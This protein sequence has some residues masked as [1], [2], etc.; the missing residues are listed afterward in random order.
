MILTVTLNAAIDKRYVIENLQPDS[1][2]R[3]KEVTC[4]AG[5]KGLNVSRIAVIAGEKVTATGFIGGHAG[6]YIAE[7]I[8]EMNIKNAFVK[9][10]GESRT[11][12]NI[13]DETKHTQTELLEPGVHVTDSDK[14]E[15]LK[16]YTRLV[17]NCSVVAIS[18]SVPK[19]VDSSLY[20]S[21][22]MIAKDIGKKVILDTSGTL[23]SDCIAAGPTMIKPNL[24]EIK[25]LTGEDML[26]MEDIVQAAVRIHKSGVEIVN[27]TLGGDGA[28][29]A[30]REG[31]YR[32]VVPKLDTV[33][34]VGCGDAA[35]AG[36]AIGLSRGLSM[37]DT[38]RL[39]SAISAA[40]AMRIETGFYLPK[41]MED[42][43]PRITVEKIREI[44]KEN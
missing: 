5:G 30:C 36:F 23:L 15:F 17:K 27:V 1:V 4:S 11:C 43:L 37:E 7:S 31:I 24:D 35:T 32:A 22:I 6:N 38:I 14:E 42:L 19:G 2:M 20:K 40:S 39:A 9:I 16:N 29:V 3:V 10:Q 13:Y 28:I 44:E 34:T 18:G 26:G 12:I 25:L 8:E 21:L 41:D 33:N